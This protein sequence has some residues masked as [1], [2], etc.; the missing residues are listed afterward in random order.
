VRAPSRPLTSLP[1][2]WVCVA[3]RIVQFPGDSWSDVEALPGPQRQ[4]V[5]R[6]VAHLLEEP[7]PT[8]A[9]PFPVDDD[10]LPS[11]YELRL[12]ADGVTIWYVV[13]QADDGTEVILGPACAR[14][15]VASVP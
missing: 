13:A 15:P 12:P 9:D 11:A 4:A 10:P 5:L 3:S 6:V 14:R 2:Q 1:R 8:L 7:V